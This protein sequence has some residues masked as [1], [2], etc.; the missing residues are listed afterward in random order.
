VE[1]TTTLTRSMIYERVRTGEFPAPVSIGR[2]AV[3]WRVEDVGW[4]PECPEVGP[5]AVANES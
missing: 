3:R 5:E 2:K 4:L 1:R